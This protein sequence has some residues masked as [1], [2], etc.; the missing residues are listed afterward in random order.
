[1]NSPAVRWLPLWLAVLCGIWSSTWWAIRQSLVDLP[2]CTAAAA[3]F[4]L[5]APLMAAAAH[6]LR[7]R[8]GGAPPPTWLWVTIGVTN[9]ALSYGIL[10]ATETI[11]PSGI[12]AVLWGVFPLLMA[13][14]GHLCLGERLRPRQ[15]AGFA[16]AFTGTVAMFGGDLGGDRDRVLLPALMLLGSPVV[17]AVGTT[18]LKRH[19][20]GTS[21]LLLNRNAM[22]LGGVLLAIAAF[23]FEREQ[24]VRWTSRALVATVYL[25]AVGTA[26]SFGLYFWLLRYTPA[27]RLA[28]ISYVTPCLALALAALLGD[29]TLDTA[30]AAG[31]LLTALGIALVVSR[32]G[33]QP[34]DAKGR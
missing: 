23:C 22:A 3:R 26:L 12:A 10:Y 33:V 13:A 21:S 11:V 18:L 5:A 19:G 24:P 34:V 17:A 15:M 8:E 14:S 31:T 2:P 4:L 7:G 32:R 29:G 6:A 20:G 27:N 28:L 25:A 9:F 16:I 1:M 30:T